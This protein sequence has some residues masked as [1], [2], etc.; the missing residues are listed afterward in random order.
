MLTN[1]Y[2][3]S[4]EGLVKI[5]R[6]VNNT[7]TTHVRQLFEYEY[8]YY[9]D[10][11]DFAVKTNLISLENGTLSTSLLGTNVKDYLA[12]ILPKVI[13]IEKT[14]GEFLDLFSLDGSVLKFTPDKDQIV[15]FANERRFLIELGL[16]K[17]ERDNLVI[18]SS[19]IIRDRVLPKLA[20]ET[21]YQLLESNAIIGE[22]AEELVV[23]F[24]KSTRILH[25]DFI[26][27]DCILQISHSDI[28]AGYDI[29]SFDKNAANTGE[30][31]PVYIEVKAIPEKENQ[32]F[33][34]SNE[35]R[36]AKE[37]GP[38]YF[39]YLVSTPFAAK[40]YERITIIENPYL[41]VFQNDNWKQEVKSILFTRKSF[42]G[43]S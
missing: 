20:I 35:I 16:I 24:E 9:I 8:M 13:S 29:T 41:N 27:E 38:R 6:S 4:L 40:D 39:L 25:Y 3:K 30:F 36:V 17:I 14:I 42:V 11:I 37:Y 18:E 43:G 1:I 34:S 31:R 10:T 7:S 19:K 23:N 22:L 33:W 12:S 2:V 28:N 26:P 15:T 21:L 5:I 32:F